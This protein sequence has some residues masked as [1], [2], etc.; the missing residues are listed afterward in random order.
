MCIRDRPHRVTFD[1]GNTTSIALTRFARGTPP[2]KCG[3][4]AER[5]NGNGSLM[6]ILPIVFYLR[7]CYGTDFFE[8]DEAREIIHNVSALTHAQDVYKRQP[9]GSD[10]PD[11]KE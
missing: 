5:D 3:G 11:R 1:V 10:K 7:S 2:L 4:K 9:K 8:V 6:R